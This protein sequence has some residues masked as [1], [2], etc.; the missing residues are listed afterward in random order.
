MFYIFER[1]E[2]SDSL[3]KISA[4]LVDMKV[5]SPTGKAAWSRETISK[6][7]ANEKYMGDWEMLSYE[8]HR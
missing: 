7:L 8:R 6:V 5:V 4:A 1:F 2:A 3:G